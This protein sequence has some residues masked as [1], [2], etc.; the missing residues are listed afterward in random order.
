MIHGYKSA[1]WKR[2]KVKITHVGSSEGLAEN[3][4]FIFEPKEAGD[5][6]EDMDANGFGEYFQELLEFILESSVTVMDNAI[7][8]SLLNRTFSYN[9]TEKK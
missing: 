9:C 5:N 2:S 8:Q 4:L 7:Y 3:G 1:V 6:H